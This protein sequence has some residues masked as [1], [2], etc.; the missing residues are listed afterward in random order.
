[1]WVYVAVWEVQT[2]E[3]QQL[4]VGDTLGRLGVRATFWTLEPTDE[5]EGVIELTGPNPSGD[6]SSHHRVVGTVAWAREP[7]SVAVTV[8]SFQ[9]MA[10]PQPVGVSDSFGPEGHPLEPVFPEVGLPEVG[11]RIALV[12][13]LSSMLD[14]EFD[15]FG[16]PDVSH[17]WSVRGLRVEHR[18]LVP[19]PAYPGGTEPGQIVRVVDIPRM[20]RW[21]DAPR[22]RHAS[23]LLD[24][25]ATS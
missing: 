18:E 10:E 21:A 25:V 11:D 14:Y 1:M 17:D 20:L 7:H 2:G 23:Y 12:A 5:E 13:T 24:L 3:V 15:A 16:Y 19:S 8:G 4:G 9:L 22:D 6:A